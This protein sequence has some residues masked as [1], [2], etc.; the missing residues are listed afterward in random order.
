[1]RNATALL[2]C[3]GLLLA[4][5]AREGG[6]VRRKLG[7]VDRAELLK[8]GRLLHAEQL[9]RYAIQPAPPGYA[10]RLDVPRDEWPPT[11]RK[12]EPIRVYV[13][14]DGVSVVTF[15]VFDANAGLFVAVRP[16]HDPTRR[17]DVSFEHLGESFYFFYDATDLQ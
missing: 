9:R 8:E 14:G 12:F 13:S 7:E 11:V 1:M 2:I 6:H 17:S 3:T 4:C 15:K 5:T 10:F 16:G